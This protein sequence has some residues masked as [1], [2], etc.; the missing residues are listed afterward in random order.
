MLALK[1]EVD[2]SSSGPKVQLCRKCDYLLD[3]FYLRCITGGIIGSPSY[4]TKR[5]N[6]KALLANA[7]KGCRLCQCFIRNFVDTRQS[8]E[9]L[10]S[11]FGERPALLQFISSSTTSLLDGCGLS[12]VWR[13]EDF[14]HFRWMLASAISSAGRN[15]H[16]L[17]INF[18]LSWFRFSLRT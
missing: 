17:R 14:T 18:F 4:E 3:H 8:L 10:Y 13:T 9:E 11:R 1:Y 15:A 6:L 7:A 5:Y 12:I 2:V 16:R